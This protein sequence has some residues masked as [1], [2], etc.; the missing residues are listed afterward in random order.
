[1]GAWLRVPTRTLV[2]LITGDA[3]AR[4]PQMIIISFSSSV[5]FDL[6][7]VK[8]LTSA[9]GIEMN[10]PL[11]P[12]GKL[13][14]PGSLLAGP[15]LVVKH[16]SSRRSMATSTHQPACLSVCPSSSSF[17][18]PGKPTTNSG[19]D[20]QRLGLLSASADQTNG[21]LDA[22]SVNGKEIYFSGHGQLLM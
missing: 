15:S 17:A 1:M 12:G 19:K 13:P 21:S 18:G 14:P 20:L 16:N 10:E 6:N 7:E 11:E 5:G 2:R 4:T 3:R 9:D 22:H 8:K